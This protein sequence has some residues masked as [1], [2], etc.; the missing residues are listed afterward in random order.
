MFPIWGGSLKSSQ[1]A[2]FGP[3]LSQPSIT[4]PPAFGLVTVLPISSPSMPDYLWPAGQFPTSHRQSGH[5][6]RGDYLANPV[7]SS[8][9]EKR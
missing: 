3:V 9:T 8:R 6:I 7:K 2:K 5:R 4:F 1:S